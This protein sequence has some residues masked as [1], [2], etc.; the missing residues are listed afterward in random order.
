[1][2][3]GCGDPTGPCTFWRSAF[4]DACPLPFDCQ[5]TDAQA[6]IAVAASC[7]PYQPPLCAGVSPEEPEFTP[8]RPLAQP[9]WREHGPDGYNAVRG[10]WVL[11]PS[12]YADDLVGGVAT[13]PKSRASQGIY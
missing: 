2:K 8:Q 13:H 5:A 7:G 4:E 12:N 1:M 9:T 6:L 11:G 3:S 10:A